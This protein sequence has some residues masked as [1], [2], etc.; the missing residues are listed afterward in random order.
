[1]RYPPTTYNNNMT[2]E[3]NLSD[4]NKTEPD[5]EAEDML[6]SGKDVKEFIKRLKDKYFYLHEGN[7]HETLMIDA[8]DKLAGDKLI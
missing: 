5:A 6:F 1:M 3:F 4:C 8:I 7:R 2:N